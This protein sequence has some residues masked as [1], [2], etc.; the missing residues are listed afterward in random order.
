MSRV[1]VRVVKKRGKLGVFKKNISLHKPKKR[2]SLSF[3]SFIT[4]SVCDFSNATKKKKR[5]CIYYYIINTWLDKMFCKV[6]RYA[7]QHDSAVWKFRESTTITPNTINMI[8]FDWFVFFLLGLSYCPRVFYFYFP[9]SSIW[10][11]IVN[12]KSF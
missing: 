11:E 8:L 1:I 4:S 9:W 2:I 5:T 7:S 6:L 3:K 12:L 10:E